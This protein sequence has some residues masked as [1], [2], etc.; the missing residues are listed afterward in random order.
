NVDIRRL[1][2]DD[3]AAMQTMELR[4]ILAVHDQPH[5]ETAL[6]ALRRI[7]TVARATRILPTE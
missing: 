4:F 3:E 1:E 6:R 2:M 7:S 5:L